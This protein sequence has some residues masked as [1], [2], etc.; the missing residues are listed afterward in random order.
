MEFSEIV[1]QRRSIKSY[2]PDKEISDAELK[3]LMQE[4]VLS[5]S[6]FNLQ[7]WT[8]IA[9]R[10]N[11]LKEKI[12]AA[13]WGQEQVL[14]CSVL[15]VV[16]GKLNAYQDAPEIYKDTPQGIQEKV[17]PIIKDFYDGKG[18]LQRDEAIRS[19]S[20]AAMILMLAAQNRGWATVPM[21]GFDPEAVSK[22]ANLR[23][24]YIPAM[25][26]TL[27]YKK[28][29]PRPRDYRRP[30]EEIVRINTLDGPGLMG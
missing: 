1:Q 25:L 11:S 2:L 6:S 26:M 28:D 13:A 27:G 19:A 18:Q 22:L 14:T 5:P 7:H 10:D 21:I 3:E 12:Q 30:I 8:F 15:L 4:V 20:L 29:D 17:L 23:P 9:V 16:C 24:N